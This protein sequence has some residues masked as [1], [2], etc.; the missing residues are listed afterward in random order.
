MKRA[1]RNKTCLLLLL[2]ASARSFVHAEDRVDLA[3]LSPETETAINSGLQY[4]VTQQNANGSFG[5]QVPVAST[6]L[7]LMA[8]MVQ[9]N[10]PERPPYGEPMKKGLDFLLQS[11]TANKRG[12]G[13]MGSSMYEHGLATLALSEAWGMSSRKD[14]IREVLK[15]A[16]ELIIHSQNDQGG[17]RYKPEPKD[18]D[19]SVTV[20]QLVALASAQ[21]AGIAVPDETIQK[22]IKYVKSSAA[23]QGGFLY[24]L[25]QKKPGAKAQM[26]CSAAGVLSLFMC[27][28]RDS[29]E[30]QL[31]LKYLLNLQD[32]K[33]QPTAHFFY[34]NYYAVQCMYQAGESFYQGWYPKIRDTL[35]AKQKSDGSFGDPADAKNPRAAGIATVNTA[36]SILILGVPYRFLPIYQR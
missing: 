36:F 26:P 35:L 7:A 22:A 32:K 6:A 19:L 30:A 16:V 12:N 10:F 3:E 4:L 11:A 2:L 27:G 33:N 25:S 5:Q 9:G 31:S 14:D 23:D 34:A 1:L 15:K 13:F 20:M 29:A 21:E 24:Q 28:E 18:A 8:F 17:W